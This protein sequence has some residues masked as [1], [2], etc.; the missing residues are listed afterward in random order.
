M[1]GRAETV[2]YSP[3]GDSGTGTWAACGPRECM[4]SYMKATRTQLGHVG[5]GSSL[6]HERQW[7]EVSPGQ[8]QALIG[9]AQ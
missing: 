7:E 4:V 2:K 6:D 8:G 9:Q 3:V 5:P 1:A